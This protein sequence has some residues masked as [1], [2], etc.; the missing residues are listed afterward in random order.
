[1]EK[2]DNHVQKK[3]TS[4]LISH[5]MQKLT[6]MDYRPKYKN[7]KYKTSI[8]KYRREILVKT[9]NLVIFS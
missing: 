8:R 1:M 2:L 6:L 4:V 5:H 3:R 9:L 7:Y